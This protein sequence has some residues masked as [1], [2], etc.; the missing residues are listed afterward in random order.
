MNSTK[1]LKTATM[2]KLNS[3]DGPYNKYSRGLYIFALD[4][5]E[6]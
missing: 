1:L 2:G 6:M 4:K 3:D 5:Q